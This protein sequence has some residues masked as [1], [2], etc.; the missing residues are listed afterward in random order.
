[1]AAHA[2]DSRIEQEVSAVDE[3]TAVVVGV[4]GTEAALRAVSWAAGEAVRRSVPL[5]IVHAA[6][7]VHTDEPGRST[8]DATHASTIVTRAYTF[9]VRAEPQVDVTTEVLYDA[10]VPALIAESVRAGLI[11]VGLAGAGTADEVLF[12]SVA[13]RVSGRMHCPLVVVRGQARASGPVVLGIGVDDDQA[14][15]YAFEEAHLR[16]ASLVVAHAGSGGSREFSDSPGLVSQLLE[17][18]AGK[19]VPWEAR[20]PEVPVRAVIAAGRPTELL[21]ELSEQAQLIV[22]GTRNRG[23]AARAVLGSTSRFLLRHAQCPVAVVG[24]DVHRESRPGAAVRPAVGA[25]VRGQ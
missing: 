14:I 16:G 10:P 21:L 19:L 3:P 20:Y 15:S 13:F 24:L 6:A 17:P 9:A 18:W 5:R 23:A 25:S 12:G 8:L 2:A 1:V 4:D 7:Y 22:V 11:V